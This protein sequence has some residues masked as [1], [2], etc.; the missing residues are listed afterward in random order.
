MISVIIPMYNSEKTIIQTLK[1]VEEQTINDF[2]IIVVDDG[3]TDNSSNVVT[4]FRDECKSPIKM[5]Q[6]KN[7]GPAKARNFGVAHSEGPNDY[8]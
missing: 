4:E 5:I 8:D 7:S 6:Q 3:S 1:G 2:E